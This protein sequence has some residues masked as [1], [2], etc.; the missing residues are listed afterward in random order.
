MSS[1]KPQLNYV[2]S[3]ISLDAE[4]IDIRMDS[5][6]IF[7]GKVEDLCRQYGVKHKQ[8]DNCIGFYAPKSRLRLFIEKL[9]FS[10]TPYSY[11]SY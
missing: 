5:Y 4:L 7:F 9:H 11:T 8:F 6:G 1:P 10:Q 3:K 2:Y